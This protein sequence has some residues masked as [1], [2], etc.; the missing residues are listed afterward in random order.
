LGGLKGL[1]NFFEVC[2]VPD[3]EADALGGCA[4]GAESV[5]DVWDG[6]VW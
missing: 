5:E 4:E 3:V 2:P 1:F 6:S